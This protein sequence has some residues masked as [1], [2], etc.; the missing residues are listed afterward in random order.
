M[1]SLWSLET[2]EY[3]TKNLPAETLAKNHIIN[4]FWVAMVSGF[5]CDL[6]KD[7]NAGIHTEQSE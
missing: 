5:S 1:H 6:T 2:V 4:D 7:E 3:E